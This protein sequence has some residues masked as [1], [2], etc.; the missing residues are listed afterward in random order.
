MR[1]DNLEFMFP[2]RMI[3]IR[4]TM[5]TFHHDRIII[6]GNPPKQ[7]FRLS[8]N[9][10]VWGCFQQQR[11]IC[12]PGIVENLFTIILQKFLLC[13]SVLKTVKRNLYANRSKRLYFIEYVDHS[14]IIGR[15]GD[16]EGNEVKFGRRQSVAIQSRDG[17]K[18]N[19]L[20]GF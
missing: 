15:K 8:G 18:Y 11:F 10:N 3:E 2:R 14:T 16:I 9:D 1:S 19:N 13:P 4:S 17:C 5:Q 7:F 6:C 20:L 12:F